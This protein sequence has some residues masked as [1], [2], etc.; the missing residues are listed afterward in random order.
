VLAPKSLKLDTLRWIGCRSHAERESLLCLLGKERPNWETRV[1]VAVQRLFFQ[2]G[3][4]VESVTLD[5]TNH[6]QF[7]LHIPHGWAVKIRFELVSESSGKT[8]R[9]NSDAWTSSALRLGVQNF[10]PG[11]IRLH[12]EDCLAYIARAQPANVP[13]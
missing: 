6:I 1:S 12:V 10:E 7:K 11:I 3:C 5:A 9:W 8:W 13:F 4:Y 2:R